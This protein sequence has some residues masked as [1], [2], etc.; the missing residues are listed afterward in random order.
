MDVQ[1]WGCEAIKFHHLF[2]EKGTVFEQWYREGKLVTLS[3][4][5]YMG[6]LLD[7]ILCLDPRIVVHRLFGECEASRLVA[8]L[9]TLEK[10]K[11]VQM[12]EGMMLRENLWQGKNRREGL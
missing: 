5:E 1:G 3:R 4:E 12:F 8:P 2:V 7:A 11:N 10:A 9:W 6:W